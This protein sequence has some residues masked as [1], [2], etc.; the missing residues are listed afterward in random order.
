MAKQSL[1]KSP[2]QGQSGLPVLQ[3]HLKDWAVFSH[4]APFSHG[5]YGWAQ[6]RSSQRG[7]NHCEVW[8][9]L[10]NKKKLKPNPV[11]ILIIKAIIYIHESKRLLFLIYQ[12]N[13]FIPDLERIERRIQNK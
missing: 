9:Q 10:K 1:T 6:R 8:E 11:K 4:S 5:L 3:W 12:M 7:P 13:F 2:D